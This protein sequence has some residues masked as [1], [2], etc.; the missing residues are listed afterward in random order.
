M[1]SCHT[2][3][4]FAFVTALLAV[5]ATANAATETEAQRAEIRIETSPPEAIVSC[6]GVVGGKSPVTIS[7]LRPGKHLV[8]AKKKNYHDARTAVTLEPRQKTTMSM[9]LEPVKALML[10]HSK[11]SGAEVQIDGAFMGHTPLLLTDLTLGR[12]E[13]TLSSPGYASKTVTLN[14]DDRTP[15]K[16]E[17]SLT[18][19]SADLVISSEPSGAKV[20]LN[21]LDMGLTPCTLERVPN[22]RNTLTILKEGYETYEDTITLQQGKQNEIS[23]RLDPIPAE[24]EI[25]SLPPKARIYFENER[26]GTT[27]V[28][29]SDLDPGQYRI[30]AELEGYAPLSR[31]ITLEHGDKKTEEFRLEK[32]SGTVRIVTIPSNVEVSID[33][34]PQGKTRLN[35]EAE[36]N[37]SDPLILKPISAGA[38]EVTLKKKGYHDHTFQIE[39]EKGKTTTLQKTLKKDFRLDYMVETTTG[40]YRGMLVEIRR[41][42]TVRLEVK[43]GTIMTFPAE[44]IRVRRPISPDN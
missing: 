34:D 8:V 41:D 6:D 18:S 13:M 15:R 23:I 4:A 37:K 12:Y 14:L 22:G 31:T 28:T 25:V 2:A 24:L 5:A 27:P 17:I 26:A 16:H 7:N 44:R 36:N 38:H 35:L 33:G 39:V 42:G 19:T 40:T 21:N 11:P 43:P 29:L 20:L 32:N 1:N 30:R 3:K 9:E 10:V